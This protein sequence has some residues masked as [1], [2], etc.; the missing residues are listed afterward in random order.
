MRALIKVLVMPVILLVITD[1][2]NA[3][4]NR[5]APGDSIRF[6]LKESP[7]LTYYGSVDSLGSNLVYI[8]SKGTP[9]SAIFLAEFDQA[10]V[11]HVKNKGLQGAL[12]G[13]G[14][15]AL[16]WGFVAMSED[17]TCSGD[18]FICV[19]PLSKG[20]L[21]IGGAAIGAVGGGFLG[22]LVGAFSKEEK[23]RPITIETAPTPVTFR[24]ESASHYAGIKF[25]VRF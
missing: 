16:L 6:T 5:F 4:I 14:S 25:R 22:F 23:W 13:A 21:F 3:Q 12:I 11:H 20:Q 2:V 15:G 1:V 9:R 8:R 7:A 10:E 19:D 24:V 18:E 17:R